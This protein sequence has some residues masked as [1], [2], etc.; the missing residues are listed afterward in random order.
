MT[1]VVLAC[2][3][4]PVPANLSAL[5]HHALDTVPGRAAIDPLIADASRFIVAGNDAA[6][7]A[8]VTRLMRRE[9]L[10]V[11]VAYVA[12]RRT[13]ATRRYGL[14]IGTRA[15]ALALTGEAH[16]LPL[17]RDDAG[18]ALVGQASVSGPHGAELFGEAYV[19]DTRLFLGEIAGVEIHPTA[20]MP[21]LRACV[22][23][24]RLMRRRWVAGRAIQMGAHELAL[25]RDGVPH[26]RIVTR[27]TFYRHTEALR[28]VLPTK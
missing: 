3:E 13:P 22:V 17:I 2:G 9:R 23:R 6:F 8:V 19:D 27:S 10:D 14:P 26:P 20:E 1:I 21:G 12:P 15:A 5:P 16:K 4:V 18:I 24:N 11:E 25:V 7:A 28:L